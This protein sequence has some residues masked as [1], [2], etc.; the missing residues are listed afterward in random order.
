MQI[1][2]EIPL[3]QAHKTALRQQIEKDE[4]LEKNLSVLVELL[5]LVQ[6][7]QDFN[8]FNKVFFHTFVV[9]NRLSVV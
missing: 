7:L 5:S 4:K 9:S 2:G 6:C 8:F 3:S 1:F